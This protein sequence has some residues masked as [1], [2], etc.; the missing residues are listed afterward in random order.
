ML[1]NCGWMYILHY[2]FFHLYLEKGKIWLGFYAF[3]LSKN[4]FHGIMFL[5]FL[6]LLLFC[7]FG[8][9]TKSGTWFPF[10]L[11]PIWRVETVV[12]NNLHYFHFFIFSFIIF[13]ETQIT[14]LFRRMGSSE[15]SFEFVSFSL[16]FFHSSGLIY[17]AA[18]HLTFATLKRTHNSAYYC[19][20]VSCHFRSAFSYI[21]LF[22]RHMWCDCIVSIGLLMVWLGSCDFKCSQRRKSSSVKS[23][24]LGCH[25]VA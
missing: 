19:Y 2:L 8:V 13:I 20:C 22:Q 12:C 10:F 4:T 1:G 17:S 7:Y 9:G 24:E 5:M 18:L 25:S 3:C 6:C 21:S 23:D 16:L 14:P 11:D 15:M